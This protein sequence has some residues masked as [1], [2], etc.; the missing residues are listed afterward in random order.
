MAQNVFDASLERNNQLNRNPFDWSHVWNGTTKHGTIT[1]VFCELVPQ[2]HSIRINPEFGLEMMPMVFPVQTRQFA[3]LNFFK[4]TLRSLWEDYMDYISNYRDDLEEPYLLPDEQ[5]FKKAFLTGTLGDYL[6]IPTR[7]VSTSSNST[8]DVSRYTIPGIDCLD[9]SMFVS[10]SPA[11]EVFSVGIRDNDFSSLMSSCINAVS[12]SSS[13]SSIP[14]VSSVNNSLIVALTVSRSIS[15]DV[16]SLSFSF[17]FLL[18]GDVSRF[19]FSKNP[20]IAVCWSGS[21]FSSA[22]VLSQVE[23]SFKTLLDRSLLYKFSVKLTSDELDSLRALKQTS[24]EPFVFLVG[25]DFH[26]KDGSTDHSFIYNPSNLE[27]VITSLSSS[28]DETSYS[29]TPFATQLNPDNLRLLAYKFRAYEA[30]YN[31]FYRDVRNDPFIIDGRP[32]YNKWLPTMK[33]GADST[34]YEL[35]QC[36]WERDM[37]T[38]CI[39]SPQQG[40]APLA[41]LTVY[42][43]VTTN[44][45]GSYSVRK[46]TA[47]VTED[48]A[49]YGITYN[50]SEDGQTLETVDYEPLSDKTEVVPIRSALDL[51]NSGLSIETLRMTNA[52]Q[53]YLELNMRKSFTYKAIMEGRYD[54]NLRFDELLMPEFIGGV[55][56][57]MSMNVS[58]QS[59]DQQSTSDNGLYKDALGSKAGIAGV[60]GKANSNIEC[61]CDEES[62]VIGLLTVT[63]VPIYTQ[64]LPKDYTYRSV[65]DHW[66]PEFSAIGYQPVTYKE[67]CPLNVSNQSDISKLEDTFGYQRPWYEHVA[68]YD[69]AH[70]L[71]RSNMNGFLMT[72]F[73]RGFPELGGAFL[74][75]DPNVVN[76]VFS[77]TEFT[78]KIFGYVKFNCVVQSPIP[79][80]AIP[81]ID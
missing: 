29:T 69:T 78:D 51:V 48:G 11:K 30:V 35:H 43:A 1:P 6:N 8:G 14:T 73:F 75:V 25:L 23:A 12:A 68:K 13:N 79:R 20:S 52:Y 28:D 58:E 18:Q 2:K 22:I 27:L 41:G 4:V 54:V 55:S 74:K 56:R 70:G 77:V 38:T 46:A 45:D 40:R 7:G 24:N 37:F 63:P 72:R 60:Y 21:A 47:L 34:P 10:G 17:S 15:V 42:D 61:F 36:N 76:Q 64:M 3:R 31:A 57:E 49:K 44:E 67:M 39:P 53:K 32:V 59:V 80:V 66:A 81:R 33:G 5:A 65:L 9:K 50:V 62:I 19:N 71:F 16:Q 26:S